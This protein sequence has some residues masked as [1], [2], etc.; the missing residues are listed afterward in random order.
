MRRSRKFDFKKIIERIDYDYHLPVMLDE[1]MEFLITDNDGMY[2]DGTLG[3]GGHTAEILKRLNP[4]GK[5]F[6]FDKDSESIEHCRKRFQ[7]ELSQGTAQ[8][9]KLT[10][11]KSCY[12]SLCSMEEFRGAL[13]GIILD[14]GVS[15]RQL[16][17]SH[18]GFAYRHEANLDMRFG[19]DGI[20][21]EEILNAAT[22]EEIKRILRDY[23]EE[24]RA[25]V[26]ARRVADA[27]R[28]SPIRTTTDLR[29]IIELA[30]SS[31][32]LYKT[33]SRVFQAFRI[34]VNHELEVLQFTLTNCV[35]Q[36]KIGGRI[37]VL[38]YH[39]LEDRIVKD[40][41]RRF[42]KPKE[43]IY[44]TSLSDKS[45]DDSSYLKILTPKPLIPSDSEMLSNPRA[46]SA[47][48]RV[49]ERIR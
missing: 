10:L 18:R 19:G 47:K 43:N 12:S 14:L 1:T 46:R 15:S 45:S 7:E 35:P 31:Y 25:G 29:K 17:S 8:F 39:S 36:L 48:L 28:V 27:R 2:I 4:G 44:N 13:Q 37:V 40:S 6:S 30:V 11:L 33:L 22:E 9:S 5:L 20:T 21:A 3:G 24:P 42:R 23:G 16:D 34:A 32:D 49:A 41:F 38:S 26:L